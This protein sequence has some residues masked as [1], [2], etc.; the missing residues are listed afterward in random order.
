MNEN[1]ARVCGGP[2]WAAFLR[3]EL[4]PSLLADVDL[5][6]DLLELGPGPGASTEWLRERV[7]RL[8]VLEL[9][10]CAA[11]ALAVKFAG[12]NVE[13][14]HGDATA[15]GFDDASFDTVG[16]FTMLHHVPTAAAQYALLAEALRVLRPGGTLFGSDSLA[17]VR[18]HH[19]HEGDVYNPIEPATLLTWLRAVGFGAVTVTVDKVL[20]FVARKA[21]AVTGLDDDH[22]TD[23]QTT[24]ARTPN[25]TEGARP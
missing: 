2:G 13:V 1:H 16:A 12:T 20:K 14:R 17:S 21:P 9:D 23:D 18:L 22:P 7:E 10:D 4:L 6:R 15:T 3:D 19:F 8:T 24:S 11:R 5:G 25:T